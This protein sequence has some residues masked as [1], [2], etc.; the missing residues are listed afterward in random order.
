MEMAMSI[1][2]KIHEARVRRLT[3]RSLQEL[4]PELLRDIGIEPGGIH[5]AVSAAVAARAAKR[6]HHWHN[7]HAAGPSFSNG[8]WPYR[9]GRAA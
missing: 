9:W 3:T 1:L 8:D 5:E 6:S 2:S 7:G 4:S